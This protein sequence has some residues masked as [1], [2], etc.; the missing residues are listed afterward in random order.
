MHN[1]TNLERPAEHEEEE[2][3]AAEAAQYS[4]G[5]AAYAPA[6][7]SH[8]MGA[9]PPEEPSS[10]VESEAE[11]VHEAA[12]DVQDAQEEVAEASSESDREEAQEDLEEAQEEYA[13][14][15]E[16]YQEE[17]AEED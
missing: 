10:D 3:H 8:V 7:E 13:D 12:E 1:V 5:Q 16:D 4:E 9:P 2:K 17:V 15:R 6:P 11:S 14:E